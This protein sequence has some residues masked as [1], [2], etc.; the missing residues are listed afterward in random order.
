MARILD[1]AGL[2]VDAVLGIDLE[3]WLIF[4]VTD[5]FINTGRAIALRWF[6]IFRQVDG[7]RYFRIGEPKVN[8]LVFLVVRR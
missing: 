8:R 1:I 2:A 7:D 5:D 6:G 4:V 3:A